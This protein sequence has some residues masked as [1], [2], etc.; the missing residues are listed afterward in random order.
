MVVEVV[1]L[2]IALQLFPKVVTV[3]VV[4]EHLVQLTLLVE[5]QRMELTD[6]AV[7][8]VEPTDMERLETLLVEETEETVL[9]LLDTSQAL[10]RRKNDKV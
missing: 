1:E 6:V 10:H 7:V 2:P 8:A 5:S 4:M 3:G 9:L